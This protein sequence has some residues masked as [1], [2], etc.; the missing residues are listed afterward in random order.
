MPYCHVSY[1]VKAVICVLGLKLVRHVGSTSVPGL[2]AKPNIDIDIVATQ[3]NLTQVMDA[4]NAHGKYYYNGKGGPDRYMF[5]MKQAEMPPRNLYVTLD[6]CLSVRNHL[7]IRDTCLRDSNI[8]DRYAELKR[9]LAKKE[10]SSTDD[11]CEAKNE[12]L[13]RLLEDAG[14]NN[15]DLRDIEASNALR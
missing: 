11:Y 5:G 2:A 7:A 8:R 4:L 1:V 6:G 12:F 15:R 9:E 3:E 13:A 14:F 10:W